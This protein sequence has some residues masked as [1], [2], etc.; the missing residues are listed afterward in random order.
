MAITVL[1]VLGIEPHGVRAR[2]RH[3]G[4]DFVTLVIG[5]L[6]KSS[7]D[8]VLFEMDYGAIASARH[9]PEFDDESSGIW[10]GDGETTIIR[11]RVHQLH[12]DADDTLIDLYLMNGPE[13]FLFRLSDTTM[14]A[15]GIGSGLELVVSGLRVLL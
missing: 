1:E 11:G 9:L 7:T 6:G 8:G 14:D 5:D 15:P 4:S 2:V 3:N 12:G 10:Q 13:F